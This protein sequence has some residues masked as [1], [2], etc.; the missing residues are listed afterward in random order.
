MGRGTRYAIRTIRGLDDNILDREFR[1]LTTN[2]ARDAD[3]PHVFRVN[4]TEVYGH[5]IAAFTLEA[6]ARVLVLDA[7]HPGLD[8]DE[9]S[10]V[11]A[12]V[13]HGG[14]PWNI[15]SSGLEYPRG[16]EFETPGYKGVTA[17][18]ELLEILAAKQR[19][20]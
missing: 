7:S 20:V 17:V 18:A 12:Y 4:G 2:R 15:D 14:G 13:S 11:F 5:G 8:H 16:H 19:V 9:A 6:G 10:I 1:N 3:R